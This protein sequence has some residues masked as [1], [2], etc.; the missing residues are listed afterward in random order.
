MSVFRLPVWIAQLA[1]VLLQLRVPVFPVP[2][3]P[4]PLEGDH[5][6]THV[7]VKNYTYKIINLNFSFV[8]IKTCCHLHMFRFIIDHSSGYTQWK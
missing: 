8:L 1:T 7:Q 5:C 4:S 6:V 3:A 2:E